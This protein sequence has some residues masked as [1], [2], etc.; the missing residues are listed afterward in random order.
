MLMGSKF[1]ITIVDHDSLSAEQ[2][3]D[4]VI[5]EI[6][7]I[8]ELISEWK[9]ESEISEVNRNAGICPVKVSRE[10][11]E[12]TQRAI[13]YSQMTGGAFDI[14]F[15]AM[16]KIWKFDG[17]MK[18]LPSPEAVK[19]S[20][21]KVGY[22][23]I[24]LDSME[25]T[26][27]LKLKGMKIGFGSIG[28]GY[29]ADRGKAV[30]LAKGIQAGIVNASGD[31]CAWGQQP[32]GKDWVIGIANPFKPDRIIK[33]IPL[34]DMAV[35]TSGNYER[36]AEIDGKRYAHIINPLTGYPVTGLCSVTVIGP[37]AEK[38][39]AFST[40][41][42]VLRTEAALEL[43]EHDVAYSCIIIT[44]RGKVIRSK[45]FNLQK[46]RRDLTW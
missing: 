22:K 23:N 42:M 26:I 30:M 3:I 45:N 7:R 17:S 41:M 13:R 8:E 34:K 18:A 12:L 32:N 35:T 43:I 1:D 16:D 36:Y 25:S 33:K 10:V 31:L 19:K 14:S 28:K 40:A 5:S 2:D 29:A 37:N 38:A 21:E 46:R 9:P 11:F 20:V 44:D 4:I 27:F 39:N 24:L 6:S 15:A